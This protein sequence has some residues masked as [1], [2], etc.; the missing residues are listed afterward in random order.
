MGFHRGVLLMYVEGF[1]LGR[2]RSRTVAWL[3]FAK[4]K[5]TLMA[6]FF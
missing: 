2:M 6:V 5:N 1:G 4:E 3:P